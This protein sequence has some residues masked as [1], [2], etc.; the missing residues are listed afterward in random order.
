VNITG[1]KISA[2]EYFHNH[3]LRISDSITDVGDMV[4]PLFVMNF[5]SWCI[6]FFCCIGGVKAEGKIVYV[7]VTFPLIILVIMLIRGLTLPGA[8]NGIA[9]YITPRFNKLLE[10]QVWSEAATQ[11]FFS[12]GPGWGCLMNLNSFNAFRNN[13]KR[14]SIILPIMDMISS[15]FSGFVVFSVL[16]FMSYKTGIPVDKVAAG[17]PALAFITYPQALTYLP[18]S[19]LWSILFFIMLY[20]LGLDTV[21]VQL[22]S[23][24]C[25]I[26][27]SYP[28]LRKSKEWI[29]FGICFGLFLTSLMFLF[30]NGMYILQLFDWYAPSFS[31]TIICS[32]ELI[33]VSYVYGIGKFTRD[34]DYMLAE[35]ISPV[36]K[37]LW[38]IIAPA[39]LI[40]IAICSVFYS[41][42]AEY[43]GVVFPPHIQL[44]GW[45]IAFAA[46]SA[47]PIYMIYQIAVQPKGSL[48]E[49]IKT[50]A[51]A[52]PEWG[53]RSHRY[54]AGWQQYCDTHPVPDNICK[55]LLSGD[56][57]VGD[58]DSILSGS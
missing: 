9:Y 37:W 53:P 18:I 10:F 51:S 58:Q 3:I 5:L 31:L 52:T 26:V 40:F 36:W 23:V 8:M 57:K 49:R 1:M 46:A 47:I 56:N 7:T 45:F 13:S 43:N 12:L 2:D 38:M 25:S 42:P 28:K 21:F 44:I 32:V 19:G 15:I 17:G 55:Q 14:D 33:A 24:S 35:K 34:A 29:T 27:D 54:R 50:S 6:I 11:V 41:T 4:W 30:G 48:W 20:T 39:M 22:E 16:G